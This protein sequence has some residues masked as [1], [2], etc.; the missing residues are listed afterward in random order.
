LETS[1]WDL[2]DVQGRAIT[3]WADIFR[4]IT[5]K[6][7]SEAIFAD[8]DAL[9]AFQSAMD[10]AGHQHDYQAT[11]AWVTMRAALFPNLKGSKLACWHFN[12]EDGCPLCDERLY[13]ILLS[14]SI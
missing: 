11:H 12:D 4:R 3:A 6:R 9:A 7:P 8:I 13:V 10:A 5:K 1:A 14:Q 2:W